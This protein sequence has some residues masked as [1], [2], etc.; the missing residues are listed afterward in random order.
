MT[1]YRSVKS[2][3]EKIYTV[4][5]DIM[6]ILLTDTVVRRTDFAIRKSGGVHKPSLYL[7][8]INMD[9]LLNLFQPVF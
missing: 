6:M 2:T 8:N 1:I 4:Y 3:H 7:K 5:N 9:K